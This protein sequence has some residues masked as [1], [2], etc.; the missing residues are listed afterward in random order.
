MNTTLRMNAVQVIVNHDLTIDYR[1]TLP[2]KSHHVELLDSK[3]IQ[4]RI[5]NNKIRYYFVFESKDRMEILK[6]M[7]AAQT[8]INEQKIKELIEKQSYLLNKLSKL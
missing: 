7:T 4:H 3:K 8:V 6:Q 1:L 2:L 5:R